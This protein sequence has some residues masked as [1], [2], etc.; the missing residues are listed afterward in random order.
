MWNSSP[1]PF[2]EKTIFNFHI[3]Y[4]IISLIW[5][6]WLIRTGGI[7]HSW[8]RSRRSCVWQGRR[9]AKGRGRRTWAK[10]RDN[11]RWAEGV[12][13]QCWFWD[14]LMPSAMSCYMIWSRVFSL[15]AA[16]LHWLW[17]EVAFVRWCRHLWD[18]GLG[19]EESLLHPLPSFLPLLP[20]FLSGRFF[21]LKFV[22]ERMCHIF[23]QKP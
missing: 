5:T 6:S 10:G 12:D 9:W 19:G 23:S 22:N 18:C 16:P 17:S 8:W 13:R 7:I 11:C 15:A 21:D 14:N 1:P 2:M 4:L 3:D 20:A